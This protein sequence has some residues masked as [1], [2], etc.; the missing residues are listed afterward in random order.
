MHVFTVPKRAAHL[1]RGKDKLV[2]FCQLIKLYKYAYTLPR[3][4]LLQE[5]R[6]HRNKIAFYFDMLFT[7]HV[8]EKTV[9][10]GR[11]LEK[12]MKETDARIRQLPIFRFTFANVATI[13]NLC[14]QWWTIKN[15]EDRSRLDSE[16][17]PANNCF[18][19]S[20]WDDSFHQNK[21]NER[22]KFRNEW[23]AL[24]RTI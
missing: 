10:N 23:I 8:W 13:M 20:V 16:N 14:N 21:I 3:W 11:T 4:S 18:F 24:K 2:T 5:W 12:L 17:Y 19:K 6:L 1:Y 22:K 15:S 7:N 9:D